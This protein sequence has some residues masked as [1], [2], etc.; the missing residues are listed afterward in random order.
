[1]LTC[2]YEHM[3][4]LGF[5]EKAFIKVVVFQANKYGIEWKRYFCIK[6]VISLGCWWATSCVKDFC[7][8]QRTRISKRRMS[9]FISHWCTQK[10]ERRKTFFFLLKNQTLNHNYKKQSFDSYTEKLCKKYSFKIDSK[11]SGLAAVIWSHSR[12]D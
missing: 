4:R 9:G 7:N 11:N 5:K 6:N 12:S 3:F 1:M 8:C 10:K 2:N